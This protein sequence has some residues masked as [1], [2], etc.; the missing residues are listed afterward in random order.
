M[1]V[2]EESIS[3]RDYTRLCNLIYSE[4]GIH[5]GAEK[6]TMLEGRIKRRLKTLNLVSYSEYC[7]Y[8]FGH[9]GLKEE[10]VH[11]IDV[12]TTNKTDFF[13][14]SGH[15]DFL[16]EKALP[17]MAERLAGRS[18]LIWSA[19]CSSGEEPYTMSIVLSEYALTHPGFRFRIQATDISNLV[20]AKA[21]LGVYSNDV[22]APVAPQLRKKYFMRSRDPGSEKQRVVPEL[23]RS[24]EFRRLNFMDADYGVAEK[25]DAIFCRNVIIYFDRPTQERILL[26]LSNCLTPGGYMFVGHAETL[27]DMNLPLVPVAP[28]LYR[29]TNGRC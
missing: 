20:L 26:K 6:K 23:R 12:V 5:L 18:F 28:A 16:V 10:L 29:R 27:H 2:H 7:D 1:T 24:I 25:V 21:E 14:E 22:V 17:E 13:R 11:L 19:G 9:E 8:L 3:S 15:F 4:A